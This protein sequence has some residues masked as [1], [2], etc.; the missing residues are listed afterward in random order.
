MSREREKLERLL[1]EEKELK[2]EQTATNDLLVIQ[3]EK[4]E[5]AE[6]HIEDAVNAA[7]KIE[8]AVDE[9]L[10][11]RIL[12]MRQKVVFPNRRA[13]ALFRSRGFRVA[14]EL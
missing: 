8:E 11:L 12:Q 5:Q 6:K 7:G 2:D 13:D 10:H 4:T 3:T 14:D 1:A 9:L